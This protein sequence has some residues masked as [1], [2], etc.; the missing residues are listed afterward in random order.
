MVERVV[1]QLVPVQA[2]Q[3]QIP[4]QTLVF[5]IQ[6]ALYVL[7]GCQVSSNNGV[8]EQGHNLFFFLVTNHHWLVILVKGRNA[9]QTMLLKPINPLFTISPAGSALTI[10]PCLDLPHVE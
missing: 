10:P 1:Y 5:S 9:L 8:I 4:G 2:G 3:A 6:A 7:A